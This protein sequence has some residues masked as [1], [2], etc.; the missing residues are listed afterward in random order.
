MRRFLTILTAYVITA[1]CCFI[2]AEV[3]TWG[4]YNLNF[5]TPDAGYVPYSD[6]TYFEMHW[7]DMLMSTKVYKLQETDTKKIFKEN[8][9]RKALGYNMYD[10]NF[11]KVKV[12][13]FK[14]YAIEGTM[15]DGT[16]ALIVDMIPNKS[17]II[18]EVTINYL[19]GNRDEAEDIIKSF[20]INKDKKPA[21]RGKKKQKI[22]KKDDKQQQQPSK[23]SGPVYEI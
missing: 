21:S 19:L 10:L 22:K 17:D 18:F 12:K 1:S 6:N 8:L 16:H 14:T 2:S 3:Y 9:Q 11:V 13:D 20:A 7:D 4:Y 23:P 15:P 5:E